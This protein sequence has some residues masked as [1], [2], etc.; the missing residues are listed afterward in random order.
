MR[1]T[2]RRRS[3]S[4]KA[5]I[6]WMRR[7]GMGPGPYFEPDDTRI[8]DGSRL[9]GGYAGSD[10]STRD[11]AAGNTILTDDSAT[12]NGGTGT[13]FL[14]DLLIEGITFRLKQGLSLQ[15]DIYP[16]QGFTS[17]PSPQVTIRRSEFENSIG[18]SALYIDTFHTTIVLEN[19]LIKANTTTGASCVVHFSDTS[20]T[21]HGPG[22]STTPWS[23]TMN[24]ASAS[25]LQ[26][27]R[28]IRIST[29]TTT[30]FTTT[31]AQPTFT[32]PRTTPSS[33]TTSSAHRQTPALN[34]APVGTLSLDP[35]L[36]SSYRPTEPSSPAI[37]SGSN[38]VPDGPARVRS[39]WWS[40]HR[41]QSRRPRRL[42]IV[43]RRQHGADSDQHQ[44]LGARARCVRRSST[45]I[46]RA[47]RIRSTSRSAAAADPT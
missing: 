5:P 44:R 28:C 42:R 25:P 3:R 11:I 26:S 41:R 2:C 6:T 21:T 36:T 4:F 30:F 16:D 31:T 29:S 47:G 38:D 12:A 1:R 10:C 14:G 15:N 40:A 45:P 19:S 18:D 20:G 22:H 17:N 43:D 24:K 27:T 32:A 35:Q 46:P 9:L 23:T 34:T 33:S 7:S 13:V 39:R 37:N 8:A